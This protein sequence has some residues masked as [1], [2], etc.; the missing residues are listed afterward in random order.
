MKQV[1]LTFGERLTSMVTGIALGN[2]LWNVATGDIHEA[3]IAL[4]V[5]LVF[6][7]IGGLLIWKNSR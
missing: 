4:I 6:A 3:R 5:A 7:A 1:D 2:L